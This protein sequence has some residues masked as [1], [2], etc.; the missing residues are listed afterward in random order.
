MLIIPSTKNKINPSLLVSYF[1]SKYEKIFFHSNEG[2][3]E[4]HKD[5][6]FKINET[7][8]HSE[9]NID[10]HHF[11]LKHNDR[12]RETFYIPMDN[13]CEKKFIKN[14]KLHKSSIL[15]LVVE[16]EEKYYFKINENEI[17]HSVEEDMISF[18]SILK[19]Y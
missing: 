18:L 8:T 5:K 11:N 4:I 16:N 15:T 14:Y 12:K 2:M 9:Y 19:L 17:T 7:D 10:K 13:K 3:F 6:V 1:V